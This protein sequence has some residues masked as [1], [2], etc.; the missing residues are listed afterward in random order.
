VKG[1]QAPKPKIEEKK[2]EGKEE[3]KVGERV[4]SSPFE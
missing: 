2:V 1:S 3:K 4:T